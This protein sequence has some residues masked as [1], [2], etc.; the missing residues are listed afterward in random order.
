MFAFVEE[1]KKKKERTSENEIK[2]L[3]RVF[4]YRHTT[5]TH[6]P[7]TATDNAWNY[8]GTLFFVSALASSQTK[9]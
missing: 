4:L 2:P 9:M 7:R 1:T 6:L 5:H 8:S 3:G